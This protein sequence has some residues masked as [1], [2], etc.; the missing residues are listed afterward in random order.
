[1]E[2]ECPR[3]VSIPAGE[4]ARPDC[5]GLLQLS[6]DGGAGDDLYRGDGGRRLF[7]F[8]RNVVYVEMD[9][10]D[11]DDQRALAVHREH[12][13][14][15]D[16]GAG[17]TAMADLWADAHV[18]RNFAACGSR[19]CVVHADWIHGNVYRAGDAVAFPGVPGD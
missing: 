1:M 18:A 13:G 9:A 14:M 19:E 17:E 5:A 12:G 15:D 4:M 6:R 7:V 3:A 2:R 10:V 16:G 11:S 8:P